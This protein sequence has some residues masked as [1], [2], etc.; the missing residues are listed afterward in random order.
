ME[1][2]LVVLDLFYEPPEQAI[3]RVNIAGGLKPPAE[4]LKRPIG[5][6]AVGEHGTGNPVLV[7]IRPATRHRMNVINGGMSLLSG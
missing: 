5:L 3:P 4:L 7:C 1:D 6:D 2:R